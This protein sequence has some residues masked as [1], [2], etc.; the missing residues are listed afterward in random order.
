MEKGFSAKTTTN[1]QGIFQF[2]L[3]APGN[4]SVVVSTVGFKRYEA[5]A[6]VNVG[7][8]TN[9]NAKLEVGSTETTVRVTGEA[10]L[11]QAEAADVTTSFDQISIENLPN[12][13]NDLSAVAYSAPGVV[14]NTGGWG[15]GN[16]T[17]NGL[18]T[19]SNVFTIDGANYMDPYRGVN[20]TGPADLMLG[21]NGVEEATV[22][23]NA[24]GGQYGQQAGAQ[25]NYVSKSGGNS[26]HGNAEYEWTG[27]YLDANTWFNS[28][29]PPLGLSPTTINGWLLLAD[30]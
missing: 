12:P 22:V 19:L 6:V 28:T 18:S 30:R 15:W 11:I 26:F 27:R 4:Y 17:V 14:Q 24:Y 16:F 7:Q 25:I 10:P 23:T 8:T 13:G 3:V 5:R 9:V 2:P 21:K 20:F 29:R 1:E